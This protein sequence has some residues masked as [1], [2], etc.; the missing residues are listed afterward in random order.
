MQIRDQKLIA[1]IWMTPAGNIL[2][3]KHRHDFV[4]DEQGYFV[5]GGLDY[6]R[7]G[8]PSTV[9]WK[10]GCVYS[11]DPHELKRESFKW[12][13]RDGWVSP[14]EMT[15]EHIQTVLETQSQIPEHIRELFEVELKYR[16]ETTDD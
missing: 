1:N 7:I 14:V 2:Q 12:G 9:G 13:S 15:T 4:Q 11:D 10:S 6:C 3:S 5:D 16:E 8:G